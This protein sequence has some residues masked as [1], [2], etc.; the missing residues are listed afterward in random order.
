MSVPAGL[1]KSSERRTTIR[2]PSRQKN[3][4]R[5]TRATGEGPWM[6][7][8]RNV[9]AEGIGLIAN[10]PFKK[11]MLLTIELPTKSGAKLG[12]PKQ[13]KITHASQQGTNG[14]WVFGGV[15]SSRLT[16]EELEALL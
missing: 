16:Q 4:A 5:L 7:R 11:G 15:F 3:P 12:L 2:H 10:H 9:S 8:I 1:P 13:I 14:W 6:V